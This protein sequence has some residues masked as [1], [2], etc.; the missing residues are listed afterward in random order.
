M[1]GNHSQIVRDGCYPMAKASATRQAYCI[2]DSLA[3]VT[4]KD[5]DHRLVVIPCGPI[6]HR[7]DARCDGASVHAIRCWR[8]RIEVTLAA[9]D[10]EIA[11]PTCA[12]E[13]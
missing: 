11:T 13:P 5:E 7:A 8:S 1:D 10:A 9:A 6:R 2:S 3:T 4:R 12:D